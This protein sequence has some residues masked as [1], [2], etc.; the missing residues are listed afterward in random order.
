MSTEL[1]KQL[2]A[3]KNESGLTDTAMAAKLDTSYGSIRRWRM[4]VLFPQNPAFVN[5]LIDQVK[6]FR[7]KKTARRRKA[8]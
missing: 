5:F 6:E 1:K 2:T 3:W 8:V 4:G 7:K